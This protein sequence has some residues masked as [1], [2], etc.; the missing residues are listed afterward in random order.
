MQGG[1]CIRRTLRYYQDKNFLVVAR[2]ETIV[3]Q[4]T[5]SCGD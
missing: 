1:G 4:V 2:K 5:F 3:S